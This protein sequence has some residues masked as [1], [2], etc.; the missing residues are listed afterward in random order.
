MLFDCCH[1]YSISVIYKVK[2]IVAHHRESCQAKECVEHI[3]LVA[4]SVTNTSCL[5]VLAVK[6]VLL[7]LVQVDPL[8]PLDHVAAREN[9]P[10]VAYIRELLRPSIE[11]TR[12]GLPSAEP[13]PQL[14]L[15]D[16]V[17]ISQDLE[18]SHASEHIGRVR[19]SSW[20]SSKGPVNILAAENEVP[21]FFAVNHI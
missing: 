8:L 20:H 7:Q 2:L 16:E 19:L 11:P 9:P 17:L 3:N 12:E 13:Q 5:G 15:V 1:G 18:S 4:W 14:V 10:A 21:S 6:D